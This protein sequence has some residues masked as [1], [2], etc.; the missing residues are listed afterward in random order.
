MTKT[1][2]VQR[3]VVAKKNRPIR[4]SVE[5]KF[6]KPVEIDVIDEPDE[7]P[8]SGYESESQALRRIE[9]ALAEAEHGLQEST[10]AAVPYDT[11]SDDFATDSE[12]C[13]I[14]VELSH[15]CDKRTLLPLT[16]LIEQ[17]QLRNAVSGLDQVLPLLYDRTAFSMGASIVPMEN[18][19]TKLGQIFTAR[20]KAV[21]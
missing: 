1:T 14:I 17:L 6:R 21:S 2:S 3:N 7:Y 12:L 10:P 9:I 15:K 13:K 16:I 8:G 11:V 18:A 5:P 19:A 20:Y 4:A